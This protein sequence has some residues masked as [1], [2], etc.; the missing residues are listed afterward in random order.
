V[1]HCEQFADGVAFAVR[2]HA[3]ARKNA[4]TG[5]HE[6]ALKISVT[7][8]PEQGKANKAIVRLL[9]DW[10]NVSKS[11]IELLSGATSSQKRF[12]VRGLSSE[13]AQSRLQPYLE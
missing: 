7:Q 8:P 10:L 11:Q 1:I 5:E 9:A 3:G 2:V 4:I 6:G 13:D 12:F